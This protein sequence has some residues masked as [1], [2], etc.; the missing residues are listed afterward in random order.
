MLQSSET[1]LPWYVKD[2]TIASDLCS[3]VNT[4][5]VCGGLDL[6]WQ[7][8][9]VV[10]VLIGS[11]ILLLTLTAAQGWTEGLPECGPQEHSHQHT[12]AQE[13]TLSKLWWLLGNS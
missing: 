8:T 10:V 6:H 7:T 12:A 4:G 3:M 13:P 5:M 11:P 9:S 2:G 1:M